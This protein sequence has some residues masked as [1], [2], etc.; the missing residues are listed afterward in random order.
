MVREEVIGMIK[1]IIMGRCSC[2]RNL[3]YAPRNVEYKN[4]VLDKVRCRCG[5][6]VKM[7]E[8]KYA[9]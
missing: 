9:S 5:R 1:T 3:N 8:V 7:R 4:G 2:G 6:I